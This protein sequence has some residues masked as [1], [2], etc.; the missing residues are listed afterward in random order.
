LSIPVRERFAKGF[1]PHAGRNMA[2]DTRFSLPLL[3]KRR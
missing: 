2:R 3:E 1:S